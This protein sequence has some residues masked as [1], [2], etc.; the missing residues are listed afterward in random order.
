MEFG[1]TPE[2]TL[3]P[4]E[5]LHQLGKSLPTYFAK[6]LED[7]DQNT[8][9]EC[10]NYS[11]EAESSANTSQKIEIQSL[12]KKAVTQQNTILIQAIEQRDNTTISS[13]VESLRQL[14]IRFVQVLQRLPLF[15]GHVD[16]IQQNIAEHDKIYQDI[17]NALARAENEPELHLE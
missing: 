4:W 6:L 17:L 15:E 8:P 16:Y 2:K 1:P 14:H 12:Y 7:F 9:N 3:T 5:E 11:V 13:S 10:F